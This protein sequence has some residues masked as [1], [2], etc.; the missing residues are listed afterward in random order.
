[1][2]VEL[3]LRN[4]GKDGRGIQMNQS[5]ECHAHMSYVRKVQASFGRSYNVRFLDNLFDSSEN[6][7]ASLLNSR[8]A[9]LVTTPTVA[10]LYGP[11]LDEQLKSL[12]IPVLTLACNERRKTLDQ[13][14]R[15]CQDAYGKCL[16]RR[17][18]LISLGGGVCTDIVTV[19]ASL[20]RRGVQH[21]RIPTT[22]VGQIDAGIGIKGAVNFLGKM[23]YLGS[24]YPPE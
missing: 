23:N 8:R 5:S 18:V 12:N 14:R 16:D 13:V 3:L 22:L 10:R 9:L 4:R 19:A 1:M 11:R 15:V 2:P 20:I 24:F 7:L 21:I 6:H 17:G